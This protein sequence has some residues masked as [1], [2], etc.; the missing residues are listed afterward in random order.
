M[1]RPTHHKD[2]NINELIDQAA[3]RGAARALAELGLDDSTAGQDIR[4]L[5]ALLTSWRRI[6]REASRSL[7]KFGI[8][9]ILLFML[10]MAG[11]VV[12]SSGIRP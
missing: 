1:P 11:F 12:Y 10:L 5:R 2:I 7:I 6:K 9:A 4:D 8:R 3:A